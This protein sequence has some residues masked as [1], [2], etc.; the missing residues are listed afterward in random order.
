MTEAGGRTHASRIR[1]LFRTAATNAVIVSP[2][3]KVDA[4]Q[5]LIDA[6]PPNV[7]VRCVTR[8]LPREIALGVSDPEIID[9]L[10]ERGASSIFLVNRLHAKLYIADDRCLVGSANVTRRGLGESEGGGNIEVLLESSVSDEG[11]AR[12]LQEISGEERQADRAAALSARRLAD[13]LPRERLGHAGSRGWFPRSRRAD[14]AFRCYLDTPTG[15]VKTSDQMLLMDLAMFDL[16]PGLTEEEFR[17]TVK[18]RL[19]TLPISRNLL[20]ATGDRT[21]TRAEALSFLERV[22]EDEE[23]TDDLWISFLN[24]MAHFFSETVMKQEISEMAL[25]RAVPLLEE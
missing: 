9:V 20:D 4:L 10:E 8:W 14:R 15:F 7:D 19:S 2:F 22:A 11:V 16:Q 24:W 23:S 5:L 6:I 1:D 18:S 21:L 12:T 25:R 3:I 17:E 13:S